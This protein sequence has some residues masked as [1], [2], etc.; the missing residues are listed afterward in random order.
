MN[1]VALMLKAPI[2]GEVKSRLAKSLGKEA[3][4]QAYKQMVEFTIKNVVSAGKIHIHYTPEEQ[5]GLMKSWL[6]DLFKFMAQGE[7]DLGDRL[8]VAAQ[9]EFENWAEKVIFLGGDCPFVTSRM[10]RD[11]FEKLGSNDLV[12]GPAKD[13]GYYL[14][15]LKIYRPEIFEGINWGKKTVLEETI[16]QATDLGLTVGLLDE[17]SDVDEIEDWQEAASFMGNAGV[18]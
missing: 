12:I 6:G 3:A 18:E 5:I 2:A 13:G 14:I 10:L 11:A 4:L 7:G 9:S 8:K 16:R 17:L 1:I 15:G